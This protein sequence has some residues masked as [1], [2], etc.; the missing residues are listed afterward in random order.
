MAGRLVISFAELLKELRI[1][2]G[3]TQEGLADKAKLSARLISDL[4]RG[5]IKSPRRQTV[6][7]LADALDLTGADRTAFEA[8]ARQGTAATGSG[9]TADMIAGSPAAARALLG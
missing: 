3:L 4:E 8:A 9:G 1:A 5:V 7:L 6:A 2:A